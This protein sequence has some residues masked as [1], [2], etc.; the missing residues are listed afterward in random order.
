MMLPKTVHLS[1]DI[2]DNILIRK[3][4]NK[5]K[6]PTRGLILKICPKQNLPIIKECENSTPAAKL[7]KWRSTMRGA[8]II[9]INNERIR[10]IKD[11]ISK[12][13]KDTLEFENGYCSKNILTERPLIFPNSM[14]DT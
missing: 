7:P 3:V 2:Y 10:T 12:S 11:A 1:T 5:G 8:Y 4:K 14:E 13:D 9:E 6:H